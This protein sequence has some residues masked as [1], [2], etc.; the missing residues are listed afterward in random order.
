M[1]FVNTIFQCEFKIILR[2]ERKEQAFV[3]RVRAR[4]NKVE[5]HNETNEAERFTEDFF[6]KKVYRKDFLP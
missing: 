1:Y 3:S 2:N 5:N 6:V 4:A